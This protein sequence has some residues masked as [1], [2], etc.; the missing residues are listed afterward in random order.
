MRI[1][2]IRHG[3]AVFLRILDIDASPQQMSF[4]KA[5]DFPQIIA[6]AVPNLQIMW[7]KVDIRPADGVGVVGEQH[8][9]MAFPQPRN[10]LFV[11][12]SKTTTLLAGHMVGIAIIPDELQTVRFVENFREG[13]LFNITM[14]SKQI[15]DVAELFREILEFFMVGNGVEA[16]VEGVVATIPI[17]MEIVP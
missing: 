13:D 9:R 4:K 8:V 7:E 6:M 1:Q 11:V 2:K 16:F 17:G 10:G 15:D 5:V 3:L 12:F 14:L